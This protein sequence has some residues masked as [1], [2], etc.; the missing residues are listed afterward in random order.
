MIEPTI[1]QMYICCYDYIFLIAQ[2]R[3]LHNTMILHDIDTCICIAGKKE[4][5]LKYFH[6]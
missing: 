5:N 6:M 4:R 2:V 3:C 1:I